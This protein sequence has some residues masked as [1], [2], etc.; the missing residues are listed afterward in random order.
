[1][2]YMT[3]PAL[4]QQVVVTPPVPIPTLDVTT[5][6]Q[7]GFAQSGRAKPLVRSDNLS[8]R[9]S[10]RCRQQFSF[11]IIFSVIITGLKPLSVRVVFVGG[12]ARELPPHWI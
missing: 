4:L 3:D 9:F 10:R 11:A 1:M 2:R 12:E 5:L 7:F 8:W 6:F